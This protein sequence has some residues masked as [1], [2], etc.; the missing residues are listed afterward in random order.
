METDPRIP[1]L[2]QSLDDWRDG[3][4][5][6]AVRRLVAIGEPAI[7][8]LIQA[9][10]AKH[11]YTQESAAIALATLGPVSIPYLLQALKSDDR[12]VRWGVA[13][14][15]A[16]MGAEARVVLP[17]VA[18][19]GG[20]KKAR[21]AMYGVWSDSWLT[22]VRERLHANRMTDVIGIASALQA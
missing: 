6:F 22:K 10:K 2:I 3:L 14:V 21:P 7:P 4:R 19:P 11:E 17:E 8:H 18:L 20:A 13:W 12:E 9:L 15:L 1:T 5:Q 16:S